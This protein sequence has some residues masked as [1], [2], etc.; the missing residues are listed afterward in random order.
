LYKDRSRV[1]TV[2]RE[3]KISDKRRYRRFL[4]ARRNRLLASAAS[5]RL[6]SSIPSTALGSAT[7]RDREEGPSSSLES[8][9]YISC[10][11]SSSM[12]LMESYLILRDLKG[13]FGFIH[14]FARRILRE[15][16]YHSKS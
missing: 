9:F 13:V 5:T 1:P 15:D 10:S 8:L 14:V 12:V 16:V 7:F 3:L 4:S 11:L 2:Q 6:L